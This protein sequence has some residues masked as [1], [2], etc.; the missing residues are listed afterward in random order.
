MR[1]AR[2][3][4]IGGAVMLMA[5]IATAQ[6]KSNA[7]RGVASGGATTPNANQSAFGD[8][9]WRPAPTKGVASSAG[10]LLQERASNAAA[11]DSSQ[12]SATVPAR[13]G[14]GRVDFESLYEAHKWFALRD[15]M[16]SM[17]APL[18]Y[19]GAV[20]AAFNEDG[21]AEKD[22][23]K[24]IAAAPN[25]D[26][27]F[28]A[29]EMLA[30]VFFRRS[31]CKEF[32]AEVH[33]LALLRPNDHSEDAGRIFCEAV[34]DVDLRVIQDFDGSSHL[35][36]RDGNMVPVSVNGKRGYYGFDSGSSISTMSESEARRLGLA[37]AAAGR[38]GGAALRGVPIQAVVVPR[39][40]V[41]N[42]TLS[43]VAFAVFS[44]KQEPFADLP[45][46]ERG[47]LGLPVLLAMKSFRWTKQGSFE[48]HPA[49]EN[50]SVQP[51]NLCLDGVMPCVSVTYARRQ[52]TFGLDTGADATTLYPRFATDFAELV[53]REGRKELSTGAG[54]DGAVTQSV[55]RLPE[56]AFSVGGFDAT[57][58]PVRIFPH[59][60]PNAT[61]HSYGNLGM[62][63]MGQAREVTID[64]Q[65]MTL[66]LE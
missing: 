21:I 5:G 64:F 25:S 20:E 26:E 65:S 57:L 15:A 37:S 45:E 19:R 24:L 9:G 22:L 42:I 18:L 2:I 8:P 10:F 30:E 54:Y 1:V 13:A 44:D 38:G 31:Q 23:R 17:E 43:D 51:P 53:K 3:A 58:R 56:L 32:M 66:T 55:I 12:N 48:I 63:V 11:K 33:A 40:V 49:L 14:K 41:G 50:T 28:E 62:D 34:K 7:T 61:E 52:L 59:V 29:H 4:A 27:A 47:I 6:A 35:Q 60:G 16:R 39:L 36:M 46:G